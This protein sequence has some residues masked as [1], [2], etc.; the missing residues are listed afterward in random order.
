[1]E[2]SIEDEEEGRQEEVNLPKRTLKALLDTVFGERYDPLTDESRDFREVFLETAAGRRV[3]SRILASSGFLGV[4]PPTDGSVDSGYACGYDEGK[5]A[6]G[7]II[8]SIIDR[9]TG[10][11]GPPKVEHERRDTDGDDR[12]LFGEH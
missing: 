10:V 7:N 5:R 8:V 2:R 3:L 1:M 6:I 4:V 11:P 12:S 9:D